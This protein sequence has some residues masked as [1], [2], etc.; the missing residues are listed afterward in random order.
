M[1]DNEMESKSTAADVEASLPSLA[2]GIVVGFSETKSALTPEEQCEAKSPVSKKRVETS[3]AQ[4]GPGAV[5]DTNKLKGILVSHSSSAQ[6]ENC[7]GTDAGLHEVAETE[8]ESTSDPTIIGQRPT[9]E[10][11]LK[12]PWR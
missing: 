4:A 8:D 2:D 7:H 9:R 3:N 10:E 11:A 12:R 1:E 6:H 5:E